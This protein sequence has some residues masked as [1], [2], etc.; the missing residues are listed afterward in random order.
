MSLAGG[1]IADTFQ[2]KIFLGDAIETEPDYHF[3]FRG[4]ADDRFDCVRVLRDKRFAYHK[5]YAP[6][7]P[8][9]QF[10]AY[11]HRMKGTEAWEKHHKAGKT[12]KITGRF[13]EPRVSE[14]F[15]DNQTDFDNVHNLIDA[16]EHQA[17]IAELKA[18]LR[19]QQLMY[20]DS[21]LLPEEMRA[22]RA[23]ANKMTVYEMVRDAKLYPLEK[24]LDAADLALDR[25]K[26]NVQTFK[27]QLGDKDS[28]MRYWA[29]VGLLLLDKDAAPA[30][31]ELKKALTDRS[32]EI[33]ALSA[34]ALFKIEEKEVAE[35]YMLKVLLSGYKSMKLNKV[36]INVFDWM[37]DD[38][39]PVFEKL[40]KEPMKNLFLRT[41]F[42][43]L[44]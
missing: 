15:Y 31:A 20:F 13:F 30:V 24:Y 19:R 18:E 9:G 4:R 39:N 10:L 38:I 11:M 21:G 2:G 28:G 36:L 44:G 23:R 35:A 40:P 6:F 27:I 3:A 37:G 26:K 42:L 1:E 14:E 5:N 43:E 17:K 12:D 7:A 22:S 34:Y 25:D 32:S 16:P 33:P 41:L 29:V 8:N